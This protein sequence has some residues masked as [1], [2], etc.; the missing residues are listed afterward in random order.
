VAHTAT[1]TPLATN[2]AAHGV[3]FDPFSGDIITN[4]AT[5]IDQVDPNT[6]AIL[7]SLNFTGAEFDQAA[8]DGKGHLFVASNDGRLAFVD[9]DATAGKLIGGAGNF[10]SIQFLAANLERHS[11][12]VRRGCADTAGAG[13]AGA[14][15]I[16]SLRLRPLAASPQ[17]SH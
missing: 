10:K 5:E 4:S 16:G 9:Y 14:P 3:S 7:S 15:R 17:L 2:R 8:E 13:F 1:L 11:P 6:G 12:I